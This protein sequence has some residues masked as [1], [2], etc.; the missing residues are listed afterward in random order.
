V[1]RLLQIKDRPVAKGL[2]LVA[3]HA[4]QIDFLL[5]ELPAQQRQTLADSW[6]GPATWLLPH[7]GLVPDWVSGAHA[8]VAVRVS[9][10]PVVSALCTA[11]GGPLVSTSAN[12]A[13]AL[14]AREA[15]QVRRYFGAGLDYLLS[16]RTGAD[17]RPTGIRDLFS[18]QIIRD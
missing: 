11:W 2:I 15:F 13:G 7:R 9:S 1:Q 12:P 16:G 5:S 8:T 4:G 6:P 17:R 14:P 3:A 18:G 10:H